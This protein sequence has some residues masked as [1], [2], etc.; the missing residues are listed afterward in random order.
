MIRRM[1]RYKLDTWNQKIRIKVYIR[2]TQI[3]TKSMNFG[4]ALSRKLFF[5]GSCVFV[6]CWGVMAI[7]I[8]LSW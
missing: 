5:G 4:T 1:K 2:A 8:N 3:V 7:F 6:K